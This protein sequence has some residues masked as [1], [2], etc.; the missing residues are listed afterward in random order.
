MKN[1][2]WSKEDTMYLLENYKFLTIEE[3]A[4][5]LDRSIM[6][7]RWKASQLRITLP[8]V[9]YTKEEDDFILKNHRKLTIQEIAEELG[10]TKSAIN[11]RIFKIR[12][13]KVNVYR[14]TFVEIED[15]MPLDGNLTDAY[16]AALNTLKVG[17]SFL[18]EKKH[19]QT[20][21]NNTSVMFPKKFQTKAVDD[22]T[23]RLW[24]IS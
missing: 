24:R 7:V 21:R 6:G 13:K 23:A 15:D 18:F 22:K 10:R 12:S 17:Q 1:K 14:K 3:L 16:G 20:I 5:R 9:D 4:L 19:Y 8:K 2:S 11:K